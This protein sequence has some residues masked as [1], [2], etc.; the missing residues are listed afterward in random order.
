MLIAWCLK[1][2]AESNSFSD[3]DAK[4]ALNSAGLR[5]TWLRNSNNA[6]SDLP[7]DTHWIMSQNALNAHVNSFGAA[8]VATPYLSLAAG[9]RE[10]LLAMGTYA[11]KTYPALKTALSF[12]TND[13][14]NAGY[15]FHLWV[16]VGPKP[17]PHLP[18]FGEEVRSLLSSPQFAKYHHEGEIAAKLYVS[19]R[20]IKSVTK[21]A[22]DLSEVWLQPEQ[23]PDFVPPEVI[24]NVIELV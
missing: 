4:A 15:V 21:F 14:R 13:G 20:Q 19:A 5:A 11:V 7:S 10:R 12:A 1:G 2:V 3:A 23:N 6:Q 16:L 9:C 24:N 8:G 17:A 22:A 18:G